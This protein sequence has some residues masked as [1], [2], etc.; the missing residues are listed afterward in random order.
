MDDVGGGEV[1]FSFAFHRLRS[2]KRKYFVFV[3]FFSLDFLDDTFVGTFFPFEKNGDLKFT[4]KQIG[5]T[6]QKL[7]RFK[8]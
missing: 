3:F 2:M 4:S 7:E 5:L 6:E 8:F 1:M